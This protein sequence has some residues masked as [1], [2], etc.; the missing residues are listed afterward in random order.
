MADDVRVDPDA[1]TAAIEDI[2]A[3]KP[4]ARRK[5]YTDFVDEQFLK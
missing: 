5:G 4:D 2:A 3:D 1:I